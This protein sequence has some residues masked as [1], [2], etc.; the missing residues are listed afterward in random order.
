VGGDGGWGEGREEKN[1]H[2]V[3]TGTK[4]KPNQEKLL[5]KKK[6]GGSGG[7]RDLWTWG[8][9]FVAPQS[10]IDRRERGEE[11]KTVGEGLKEAVEGRVVDQAGLCRQPR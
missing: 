5:V 4:N 7:V 2:K 6:G 1:L 9:S 11:S 8:T 10:V 3:L